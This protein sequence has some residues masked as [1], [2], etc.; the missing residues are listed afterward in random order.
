MCQTDHWRVLDPCKNIKTRTVFHKQST[1]YNPPHTHT[2]T[3]D[4]LNFIHFYL[5]FELP[6]LL[7]PTSFLLS[8]LS[9]WFLL[10]IL[11]PLSFP[12]VP[13]IPATVSYFFLHSHLLL[14]LFFHSYFFF[15]TQTFPLR[16]QS[17]IFSFL[18]LSHRFTLPTTP[19]FFS[20]LLYL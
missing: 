2:H 9:L 19:I 3:I 10:P 4:I 6:I 16:H 14:T 11:A 7:Y 1:H 17:F 15:L 20:S 12:T 8:S 18:L 13:L 5:S